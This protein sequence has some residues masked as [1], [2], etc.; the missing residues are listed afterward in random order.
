MKANPHQPAGELRCLL[1]T[2]CLRCPMEEV[3]YE[4]KKNFRW[5]YFSSLIQQLVHSWIFYLTI[6]KQFLIWWNTKRVTWL[7]KWTVDLK[8]GNCFRK[9][10]K[11]GFFLQFSGGW[12]QDVSFSASGELLAFVGH[13]S[14]ISVVNGANNQ[15]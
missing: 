15:Q 7:W 14:S 4:R 5:I 2:A 1:P 8:A 13:D 9:K 6:H 3:N 12:V 11:T 10:L